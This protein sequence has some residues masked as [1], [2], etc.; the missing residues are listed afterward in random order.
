MT[1]PAP[2]KDTTAALTQAATSAI[3]REDWPAAERALRGLLTRFPGDASLA[4]NLGLALKRQ[5]QATAALDSFEAA[6]A[7]D[8]RH[9]KAMFERA[10][11]LMD[12]GRL[13]QAR[14]AFRAYI[15]SHGDDADAWL[16]AGRLALRLGE[17]EAARR[18]LEQAVTLASTPAAALALAEA[19]LETGAVAQGYNRALA[20]MAQAPGL[21]PAA[22]KILTQGPRGRIPLSAGAL[23]QASRPAAR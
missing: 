9:G 10:A 13:T 18:D 11:C 12:L 17:P 4:Y 23:A 15:L 20:V 3:G 6:L 21:R 14:A 19:E 22:L 8:P 7:R 16:N 1:P 5:G 2:G